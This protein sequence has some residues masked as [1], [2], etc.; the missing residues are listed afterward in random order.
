MAFSYLNFF[1]VDFRSKE[2]LELLILKLLPLGGFFFA[3]FD[4]AGLNQLL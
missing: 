3:Y 4:L 2:D 1:K